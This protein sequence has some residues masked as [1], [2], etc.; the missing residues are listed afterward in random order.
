MI[1]INELLAKLEKGKRNGSGWQAACPAHEDD[2][3]SL[4]LAEGD[5][6]RILLYCHAGCTFDSIISVLG[7]TAKDLMVDNGCSVNGKFNK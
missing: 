1:A 6:G 5:D 7:L 4:S 2:V 3:P